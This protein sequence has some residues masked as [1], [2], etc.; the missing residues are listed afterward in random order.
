MTNYR[1]IFQDRGKDSRRLDTTYVRVRAWQ[2]ERYL[3]AWFGLLNG[4]AERRYLVEKEQVGHYESMA[5]I[6]LALAI[7]SAVEQGELDGPRDIALHPT[8]VLQL[9]PE[10]HTWTTGDEV[11][12]FDLP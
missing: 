1:V 4:R 6:A 7:K 8:E 11:M 2:G 9:A 3:G 5:P 12:A 10:V